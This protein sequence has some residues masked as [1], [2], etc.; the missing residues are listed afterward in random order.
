MVFFQLSAGINDDFQNSLNEIN[1]KF[2]NLLTKLRTI[3][4]DTWS[5]E[6]NIFMDEF[7][8][9]ELKYCS[10]YKQLLLEKKLYYISIIH[11]IIYKFINNTAKQEKIKIYISKEY[12]KYIIEKYNII[13]QLDKNSMQLVGLFAGEIIELS[14][15]PDKSPILA[16]KL[17]ITKNKLELMLNNFIEDSPNK[18]CS[19]NLL[20]ESAFRY[21]R[22]KKYKKAEDMCLK[23]KND[24]PENENVKSGT[25]NKQLKSLKI[26]PG[27]IAPNFSVNTI[28]GEKIYLSDFKDKFLFLEFWSYGCFPS[29]LNVPNL[30]RLYNKIS[31]DSINVLGIT[32]SDMEKIESFI[33]EQNVQY[34]IAICNKNIMSSYGIYAFPTSFLIAPSNVIIAKDLRGKNL[35]KLVKNEIRK[36]FQK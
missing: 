31:S 34:P 33:K 5:K 3:D 7:K 21:S 36:Y 35:V 9:V 1:K 20:L 15:L 26:I 14:N 16:S 6:Y 29:K 23:L 2:Q 10:E 17:D 12:E 18:K 4:K 8:D 19:A 22:M 32:C 30:N 28:S 24:F 27:I 13:K 11:P 25:V